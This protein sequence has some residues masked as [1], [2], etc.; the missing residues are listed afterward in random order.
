MTTA[1]EQRLAWMILAGGMLA[2]VLIGAWGRGRAPE[3]GSRRT[4]RFTLVAPDRTSLSCALATPVG[5]YRCSFDE[6]P[7]GRGRAGEGDGVPEERRL[8]P[9]LTTERTLYLVPGLFT[10]P[11]LAKRYEAEHTARS[12]RRKPKRFTAECEVILKARVE[13][14]STRWRPRGP[15]EPS[16]PAW[17]VEPTSCRVEG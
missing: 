12:A 2:A 14:F 11:E 9:Y 13:R 6:P 5:D 15:W 17:V 8:A 3:P 7:T 16:G 1:R 10:L 4:V